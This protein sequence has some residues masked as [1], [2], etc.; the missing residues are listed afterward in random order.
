VSGVDKSRRWGWRDR[1]AG[2]DQSKKTNIEPCGLDVGA[3]VKTIPGTHGG[4]QWGE[5]WVVFTTVGVGSGEIERVGRLARKT[6]NRAA[7]ARFR[8]GVPKV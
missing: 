3:G 8:S 7:R 1:V 4:D 6:E 2:G 5:G